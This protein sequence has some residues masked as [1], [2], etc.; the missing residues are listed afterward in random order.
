[1]R[2]SGAAEQAPNPVRQNASER[3]AVAH[4]REVAERLQAPALQKTKACTLSPGGKPR[5]RKFG[6]PP[7]MADDGRDTGFASAQQTGFGTQVID[8]HDLA[9]RLYHTR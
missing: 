6:T 7:E 9:V 5:E 3:L 8:Q 4:Q 2:H 1:M